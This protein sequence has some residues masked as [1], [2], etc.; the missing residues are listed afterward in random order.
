MV[1]EQRRDPRA[2][3]EDD[4]LWARHEARQRSEAGEGL[5]SRSE[6]IPVEQQQ[7]G[8]HA[9]VRGGGPVGTPT[10]E[11]AAAQ[12]GGMV[13]RPEG[14]Y[15][16]GQEGATEVHDPEGRGEAAF[17]EPPEPREGH[18]ARPARQRWPPV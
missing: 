13:Q 4:A 12:K 10:G 15:D 8:A 2:R 9:S 3:I 1:E 16:L 14:P 18:E 5:R 17:D 11:P 6:D 7:A